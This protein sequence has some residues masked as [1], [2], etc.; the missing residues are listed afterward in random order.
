MPNLK[1]IL[2]LVI[3]GGLGLYFALTTPPPA[4]VPVA[5]PAPVPAVQALPAAAMVAEPQTAMVPPAAEPVAPN[6]VPRKL[7]VFEGHWQG[8][9]G[10]LM[11]RELSRKLG[12]PVGLQGVLLGEVTLNGANSGFLAGDVIIRVED[13]PITTVEEFQEASRMVQNR[14]EAKLT[15]I[16]KDET[17]NGSYRTMSM[18]LRAEGGLGFV[19]VEGAPMIQAGD[20]RPHS[21]RGPCTDCH[22]VGKGFELTPD[23]DLINLPPP[24]I[25]RDTA[26]K[27]ISPHENRGPCEACHLIR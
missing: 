13:M 25:T 20:P 9:D 22:P 12:F 24:A 7:K 26:D 10:R 16:R 8:L 1:N 23:P 19:Q 14:T 17:R 18:M 27:A 6:Y 15:V 4:T 11:T 3:I 5:A 2:L 21:Y